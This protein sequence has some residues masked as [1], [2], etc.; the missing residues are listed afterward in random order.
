MIFLTNTAYSG[1][2]SLQNCLQYNS[3]NLVFS[4]HLIP[5]PYMVRKQTAITLSQLLYY[6]G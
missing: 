2:Q 5:Y 3:V 4:Y 6:M 1:R